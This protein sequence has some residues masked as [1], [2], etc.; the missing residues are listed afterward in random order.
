MI[1]S[2]ER[3]DMQEGYLRLLDGYNRG[4]LNTEDAGTCLY[5]LTVACIR[6]GKCFTDR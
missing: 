4:L 3:K 1:H 2:A 6:L 5:Y